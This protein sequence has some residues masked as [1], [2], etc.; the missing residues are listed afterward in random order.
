MVTRIKSARQGRA[1][2]IRGVALPRPESGRSSGPAGLGCLRKR[3]GASKRRQ[4]NRAALQK[5]QIEAERAN[6]GAGGGSR[7]HTAL[8]PTDFESAASAIPPLRHTS[9]YFILPNHL[10]QPW[11][12]GWIAEQ[13]AGEPAL[14]VPRSAGCRGLYKIPVALGG[15]TLLDGRS[16]TTLGGERPSSAVGER[17]LP[18][19]A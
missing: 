1:L 14:G 7:T 9:F 18:I 10:P 6:H 13:F 16:L 2:P 19:Y 5:K 12:C 8:R 3:P 4:A 17:P 11:D 15:N